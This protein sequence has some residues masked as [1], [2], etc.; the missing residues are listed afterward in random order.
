MLDVE[1]QTMCHI[2]LGGVRPD[3]AAKALVASQSC[4]EWDA[5]GFYSAN[6][7]IQAMLGFPGST[8][9]LHGRMDECSRGGHWNAAEATSMAYVEACPIADLLLRIHGLDVAVQPQRPLCT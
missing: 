4:S 3:A 2:P 7:T 1:F 6:P 5:V 9:H 8:V